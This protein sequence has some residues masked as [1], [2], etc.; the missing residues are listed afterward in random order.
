[1]VIKHFHNVADVRRILLKVSVLACLLQVIFYLDNVDCCIVN[2]LSIGVSYAGLSY[3]F[4][5]KMLYYPIS[6]MMLFGYLLSYFILPPIIT[7]LEGKQ[8][9]NNLKNP[10]DIY[11]HTTALFVT[12]VLT[13]IIY[14]NFKPTRNVAKFYRT[15]Y[16]KL[17]IFQPLNVSQV[18]LMGFASLFFISITAPFR[19]VSGNDDTLIK[20]LE[21]FSIISYLPY[22]LFVPKLF[23]VTGTMSEGQR[24]LLYLYPISSVIVG[25]AQ[26]HRS[27]IFFGFTNIG[28][29]LIL[30]NLYGMTK[31]IDKSKLL[32]YALVGGVLLF[33]VLPRVAL[34]LVAVREDRTEM[35]T[36][37]LIAK[38]F[39]AM[40]DDEKIKS[41]LAFYEASDTWDENY[42]DNVFFSRLCNLKYADNSIDIANNLIGKDKQSVIDIEIDRAL[43]WFPTPVIDLLGM[44]VNKKQALSGSSG[45][46]LLQLFTGDD[47]VVGGFRVGNLLGSS[48]AI[49]DWWY[50]LVIGGL[51]LLLFT[52]VDQLVQINVTR[53]DR[54]TQKG[55]VNVT[56][57]YFAGLKTA[58]LCFFCTSAGPGIESI[59][60]FFGFFFRG[61]IE[62]PFLMFILMVLL[63]RRSPA[64]LK[65]SPAGLAA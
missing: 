38:T 55:Q 37:E 65:K 12:L 19:H 14:R 20:L 59:S 16:S 9:I 22:I 52:I 24:R 17:T 54:V 40:G 41:T 11:L 4:R 18:F 25:I 42:V 60:E 64:Y 26:N 27:D 57:S 53:N 47:W 28:L 6:F 36:S 50:L 21:G 63:V 2:I 5:P 1:M 7:L 31:S 45:D 23:P 30:A 61:W 51:A 29:L 3:L 13:H 56:F 58:N 46:F 62:V 49:F 34:S 39:D 10:L 44:K 8:V 48:Y 35:S 43:S 33:G 15:V 32:L